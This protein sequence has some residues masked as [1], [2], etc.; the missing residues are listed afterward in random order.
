MNAGVRRELSATIG[1]PWPGLYLPIF[2]VYGLGSALLVGSA[3]NRSDS[4]DLATALWVT[5]DLAVSIGAAVCLDRFARSARD[6]RLPDPGATM[7]RIYAWLGTFLVIVPI[8]L[9]RIFMP[10]GRE[11]ILATVIMPVCLGF[12]RLARLVRPPGRSRSGA[13]APGGRYPI[14]SPSGVI[15]VYVGSAFAPVPVASRAFVSRL[16][17]AAIGL[18]PLLLAGS[19]AARPMRWLVPYYLGGSA[20]LIWVWLMNSLARFNV[21]RSAQ[22]AELALLPGLGSAASQRRAFY[23]AVL[24][25]PMVVLAFFSALA[26]MWERATSH[27]W[28]QIGF[29]GGVLAFLMLLSAVNIVGQL[30]VVRTR[31]T[32]RVMQI[33]LLSLQFYATFISIRAESLLAVTFPL[34]FCG[35]LTLLSVIAVVSVVGHV[36]RLARLPHPF[37][38]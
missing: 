25:P 23:R 24:G 22:F 17:V 15:R 27:P 32:T 12:P 2:Y 34:L 14:R 10:G 5:G 4:L 36:R 9:F 20:A 29:L 7:R 35:S 13:P 33:Y 16:S 28:R 21:N 18:A 1:M 26:L 3:S 19:A 11:L 37:L 30:L 6:L 38:R 8:L 31:P